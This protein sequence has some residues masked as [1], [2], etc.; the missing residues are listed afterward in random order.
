MSAPRKYPEGIYEAAVARYRK[1]ERLKSIAACLEVP[2]W[3][4]ISW[5]FPRRNSE[6]KRLSQSDVGQSDV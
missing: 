2:Y 5:V 1:R 3:T 6:R 4:I